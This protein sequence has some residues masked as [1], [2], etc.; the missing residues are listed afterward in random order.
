MPYRKVG[1]RRHLHLEDVMTYKARL[2]AQRQRALQ[3]LADDLQEMGL[4]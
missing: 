3:A 2:N 1:P 4:D